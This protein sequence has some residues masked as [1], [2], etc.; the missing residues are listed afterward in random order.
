[1]GRATPGLTAGR[2]PISSSEKKGSAS[3]KA[4]RAKGAKPST[5]R[6]A[7]GI[8]PVKDL[9]KRLAMF[10]LP[11]MGKKKSKSKVKKAAPRSAPLGLSHCAAKFALAISDPWNP[12][13]VGVCNPAGNIAIPSLK[14][15][16]FGR[17]TCAVGTGGWGFVLVHP[18]MVNGAV[19]VTYSTAEYEQ[20]PDANGNLQIFAAS[21][22]G[23]RSLP[24]VARGGFTNAPANS[25]D[26]QQT[27]AEFGAPTTAQARLVSFGASLQYT[28]TAM[29][30]GGLIY[31]L[32][33]PNHQAVTN[34]NALDDGPTS[35]PWIGTN[36]IFGF[37]ETRVA[38]CTAEK[39]W[40]ADYARCPGE[41]QFAPNKITELG[42]GQTEDIVSTVWPFSQSGTWANAERTFGS[43][44]CGAPTAIFIIR[45]KPGNTFELEIVAH[46]EY[47][48]RKVQ[49][50]LT[51]SHADSQGH[52]KVIQA[53]AGVGPALAQNPS[54]SPVAAVIQ[55]LKASAAE[56]AQAA[57]GMAE[58]SLYAAARGATE[59]MMMGTGYAM[60]GA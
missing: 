11:S 16:P 24:G 27:G 12:E 23:D 15:R 57:S 6:R 7:T 58:R 33:K 21:G 13:A 50:G 20:V 46:A 30:L 54:M 25:N 17:F 1:M 39:V 5:N 47:A 45:A 34:V 40:V 32:V 42:F 10:Q 49:Y 52:S 43:T 36:E 31:S 53:A 4:K 3:Q 19:A 9:A 29:D 8:D 44:Y 28:G 14:S 48:G 35:Q 2:S 38:R 22:E 18:T 55:G 37:A 41:E 26:L 60:I 59:G 51:P 56:A